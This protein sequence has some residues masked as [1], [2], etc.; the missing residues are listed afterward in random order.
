MGTAKGQ[1]RRQLVGLAE[2]AE[3]A[4]VSI[5]TIRRRISDGSLPAVRVGPKLLKVD[6]ADLDKLA[7]PV[8]A[9]AAQTRRAG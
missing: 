8:P 9:A 5:A 4:D 2:A 3:R 1:S 7:R 6:L